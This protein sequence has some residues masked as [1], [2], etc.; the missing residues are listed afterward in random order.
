MANSAKRDPN[1]TWHI[2]F[3]YKDWTGTIRKT[4][5]K[6][7]K[8]KK[9]AEEWLN[10]FLLQ[11]AADPG[12]L[13]KDFWEIYKADMGKRLKET[14]MSNKAYVVTDKLLPYFGNMPLNQITAATIRKW[15]GEMMDKGFKATYLKTINNQLSAILNYA[16]N[17][18][19]LKANP[20]K[21]AGSM[22]KSR[23]DERP[24]WILEEF[25][26][27]IDAVSDKYEAW[28]AFQILFWTGMRIGE[29]L[30][31]KVEDI[32]LDDL[33]V[34]IDE[35]YTRLNKKDI[36][37]TPKTESSVRVITIHEDLAEVIEEYISHIYKAKP[38]TRLF[39]EKTKSFFEKEMQ[40]GIKNSGV[41]RITIHCLR[42]SH[43]SML[44]ELG[45]SAQ[46]IAKRLGHGKVTTTIETY[47]HQSME[48]QQKIAN[49][50]GKVSKGD[51]DAMQKRS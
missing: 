48:A 2:Q 19:D 23:A 1:G 28:V 5:R 30:A 16:V 9:E 22:G 24:F 3:R 20:C 51:K 47:C 43:A 46:A 7:F 4:S 10:R 21:R 12:M 45:F 26:S 38:E 34:R 39:A 44:V 27:F 31:L 17:Y 6:G 25:E 41:K 33:T 35:S 49:T 14:T 50:L 42:H 37:S 18:Y 40:R 13:F 32:D 36:I 8:T 15:Q 29:L 11:Q